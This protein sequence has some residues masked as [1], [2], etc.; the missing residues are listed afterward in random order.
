MARPRSGWVTLRS[1]R[2]HP[3]M[4]RASPASLTA[5]ARPEARPEARGEPSWL[6]ML[7]NLRL[8][9]ITEFDRRYQRDLCS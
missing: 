1:R 5:R 8:E 9:Y 6:G 4:A 3:H 2:Q 7:F